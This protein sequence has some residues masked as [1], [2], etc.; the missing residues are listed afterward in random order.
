MIETLIAQRVEL[1]LQHQF[2]LALASPTTGQPMTI[3]ERRDFLGR[4]FAEIARGMG[5]DRF[6]ETPAERLDQFAVMSVKKNHD[7]A[8]LLRSLVNS[9]M[10]AYACPETADR[11]FDALVQIE[12][13]RAEVADQ[14]GQGR[15]SDKHPL[16][17][18]AEALDVHLQATL[19]VTPAEKDRFYRVMVG[20]DRL[21]VK[22]IQPLTEV[23]KRFSGMPVELI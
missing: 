19:G 6:L 18:A 21:Y 23:P 20:A 13:L 8:G 17:L 3:E 4:A 22:A 15:M 12:G 5:V 10:I 14:K 1:A 11:A 9:F 16:I 7:T 2:R